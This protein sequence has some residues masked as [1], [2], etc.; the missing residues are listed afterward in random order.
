MFDV[1]TEGRATMINDVA[2]LLAKARRFGIPLR[3]L[4]PGLQ[5][6]T[7]DQA[8]AIQDATAA[9][10]GE[11]IVGWKVAI[12]PDGE[13]MRGAIFASALL[14][15]PAT[16]PAR[17]VSL[18]G[19]EAEIAFR[20][21]RDLPPCTE[22]Y[23]NEEVAASTTAVV[24]IGVVAT[25]F[26]SYRD[27]PLLDR[28]ADC[29]SNGALVVGTARADWRKFDLAGLEATL[30]VNGAVLV[31]ARG[32]H[33]AGHPLGPAVVLVN[34]LRGSTGVKAGQV[35][36]TGSFTGL[37]YVQ[38]GDSVRVEFGGFGTAELHLTEG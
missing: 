8:H 37:R 15:S 33:A 4:P 24:A 29:M 2:G 34:T 26:T 12:R 9:L 27:T 25:R 1:T 23:S 17:L 31:R 3:A 30:R 10:L 20:F 7:L 13:A 19:I 35:I 18:L 11:D 22:M 16:L 14:A 6:A 36:T 38:P 32:G 21:D 5:P 28:T